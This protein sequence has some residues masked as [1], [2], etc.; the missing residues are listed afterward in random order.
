MIKVVFSEVDS[1]TTREDSID[2]GRTTCVRA[3]NVSKA[4]HKL[5]IVDGENQTSITVSVNESIQLKKAVSATV[6][7]TSESV[8]IS[9][10]SIY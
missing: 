6:Y 7:A 10:V 3:V 2:C 5:F 1:P 9:G 8:R 4:P